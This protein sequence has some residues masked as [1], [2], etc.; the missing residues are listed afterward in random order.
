MSS[1]AFVYTGPWINYSQ[2]V[3][4]GATI[5]LTTR[6]GALLVAFLTLVVMTAGTAFWTIFSCFCHQL[7]SRNRVHDAIFYQQQAVL[8]NSAT[9]LGAAW[10][11]SR[12]SCS[13]RKHT[14]TKWYKFWRSRT[15]RFV[16]LAL[17]LAAVFG[18]AS[19]FSSQVTKAA[20]N[21][22]LLH[23][24]NCGFWEFPV[25]AQWQLKV[26]NESLAASAY[27]RE[28]DSADTENVVQCKTYNVP[29]ITWTTNQNA[30]CPFATGTCMLGD[31]AAYEMDTGQ[32]DS[33]EIPGINSKASQRV[34]IRKVSTCAPLR[35]LPYT[36]VVNQ[37]AGGGPMADEYIQL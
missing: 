26:L 35:V 28:C 27:A 30:T 36:E 33:R 22:V 21:E 37:T 9:A 2:G 23:S 20:G 31:T 25:N 10:K 6:D 5:T 13:W 32:L 1:A 16:V 11:F 15:R 17:F 24:P 8:K 3:I 4:L 7:R 19:V 29:E 18:V 12:V 14:R 34:I